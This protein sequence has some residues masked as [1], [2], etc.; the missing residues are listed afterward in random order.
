MSKQLISVIIP[1]YKGNQY[2]NQALRSVIAASSV[3]QDI[4]T[5]EV[6]IIN[7]SP[8]EKVHIED[9]NQDNVAVKICNN[10]YNSGIQQSRLNGVNKAQ[11]S[12]ILFL[13]QDDEIISEG[14]RNQVQ[15]TFN[16]KYNLIIGNG[17]YE[18]NSGR[19]KIYKNREMSVV[20]KRQNFLKIRNLIPSPGECLLRKE[21]IPSIWKDNV[22][23]NNGADDW[24]LWITMF[25][26]KAIA[27]NSSIVY[28]HNNSGKNLSLDYDVMFTSAIE[29]LSIVKDWLPKKEFQYLS[30]AINFKFLQD[31][32]SLT[33]LRII[34]YLDCIFY[35]FAF[36][37]RRLFIIGNRK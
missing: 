30:R 16:K 13:D 6:I 23:H 28:R 24:F 2:I 37:I 35:N 32:K 21:S 19:K 36:K 18:F 7:D 12:W 29:M 15:L 9:F 10:K 11:G 4:S 26:D 14:F 1:F 25:D 27:L 22:L 31:K 8:E 33:P 17:V 3:V 5:L 34:K 20:L